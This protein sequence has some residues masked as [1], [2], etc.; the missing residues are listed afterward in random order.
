MPTLWALPRLF[1]AYAEHE[2][3]VLCGLAQISVDYTFI[4]HRAL[5]LQ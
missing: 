2:H 3:T 1:R 5:H 4:L